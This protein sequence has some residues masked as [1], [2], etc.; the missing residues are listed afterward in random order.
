MRSFSFSIFFLEW[1]LT[2]QRWTARGYYKAKPSILVIPSATVALGGNFTI[3]FHNEQWSD[4]SDEVHIYIRE[5]FYPKPNVSVSPS[6]VVAVGGNLTIHCKNEYYQES[7]FY[8]IKE[9]DL[10][11]LQ[12]KRP[13]RNLAVFPITNAKASDGGIYWC[14]YGFLASPDQRYSCFS[15]KV[16]INITDPA[17]NKPSIRVRQKGPHAL[18][19][20]V[21]ILCEGPEKGLN[22]YF[23]KSM[24]LIASQMAKSESYMT[25]FTINMVRLEDAGSYTCQYHLRGN[26]FVWSEPSD[27]VELAVRADSPVGNIIRL[28]VAGL[29]LLVLVL[30][31]AEAV[32]LATNGI[33]F[34]GWWLTRQRWTARG[35]YK[36]KPSISVIPSATVALGGNFTI[37][38][39]SEG[40]QRT[41]FQLYKEG[42]PASLQLLHT[43]LT[44]RDEVLFP[45][46]NA[47]QAHGGIYRCIFQSV[48]NEQWSDYSDEVHIYIR[49]QFYPKPN[50][51]VSPSQVV[52]VG[53]NLTILCKNEYYQES[54]FYLIKEGN[55]DVLQ[56]KRPS[57]NLAVF[58][59]TNAKASDG[60]IYWC[61]YGF[62]SISDHRYS[63]FSERVYIN[64]TDPALNKPSIKVRQKGP[65][66]LGA[67]VKMLCQG[68]EK[69]LNFYLYK[70]ME[71]IPSQTAKLEKNI[72]TFTINMV[73]LEDAGSYTCQYHLRGNPFVWS[74]PSQPVELVVRDPSLSKPSIKVKPRGEGSLGMNITIECQGPE[75][76]L[77]YFL[78]KSKK[79]IAPQMTNPDRNTAEFLLSLK[80]QEDA[81]DYTCQYH[82]IG[83]PFVWSEPSDPVELTGSGK[84][85][86][87]CVSS[88]FLPK[89]R[90]LQMGMN[91]WDYR[92]TG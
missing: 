78:L 3:L 51:S 40:H 66:A 60:G 57:W 53:E 47:Q 9:G 54:E 55:L 20:K 10:D 37:L 18:G 63:Y 26:P 45:I 80:R 83:N 7:E 76:D 73:R 69:G 32:Y 67:K 24:E 21:Q 25:T 71:L 12:K 74:E 61:Y 4:F 19:A 64:I 48:H 23:H 62:I 84:K 89:S 15:D 88:P 68:P 87:S 75:K 50:V 36:P 81:T 8:L 17:L 13:R 42:P 31:V 46:V 38:C 14:Y 70:S 29:V 58:P 91:L 39:K 92:C 27:P 90:S 59:I 33:I 30:I 1:W 11:V 6:Q 79:R 22:F 34:P 65:H 82:R 72:T 28:A 77:K 16:Y 56:K 43:E 85:L 35:Y 5:Q 86:A 52:A 49:E 2:R 44:E 41:E